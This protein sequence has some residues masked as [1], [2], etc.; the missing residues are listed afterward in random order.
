MPVED[1][2]DLQ[3]IKGLKTPFSYFAGIVMAFTHH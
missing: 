2:F 1:F 3:L